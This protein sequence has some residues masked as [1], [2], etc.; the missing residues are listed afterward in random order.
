MAD[1]AEIARRFGTLALASVFLIT[2]V[3]FTG[4]IFWESQNNNDPGA[5]EQAAIQE[6]LNKQTN[7]GGEN[8]LE[9]TQLADFTP[10]TER[11]TEL[12][13]EDILEGDGE[14]VREGA[15]VT[16][17]YTGAIVATGTIFQSSH[18]RGEPIPFSLNEVIK[19]WGEGVPGMKVGGKRRLIIPA[20]KAYGEAGSPPTIPGDSD[21][22]F[23]I[24][25]VGVQQ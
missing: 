11:V 18:D 20:A 12:T 16:A 25:I 9:G 1:K 10:T 23:D 22:V 15:T 5:A 7:N 8:M 19:G 21:L 6:A 3:A 17:H 4:L 14:E 13:K 24:E 2:T